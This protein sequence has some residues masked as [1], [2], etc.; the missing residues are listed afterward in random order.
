M[1]SIDF[2]S[3]GRDGLLLTGSVFLMG[4]VTAPTKANKNADGTAKDVNG[5]HWY[6]VHL[7]PSEDERAE[8]VFCDEAWF[9]KAATVLREAGGPVE[10]EASVRVTSRGLNLDSLAPTEV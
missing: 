5:P 6:R 10:V 9:H 1:S 8:W 2:A 4:A 7:A 3:N